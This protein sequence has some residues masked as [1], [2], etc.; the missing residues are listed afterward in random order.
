MVCVLSVF[1]FFYF[2]LPLPRV[3]AFR[4]QMCVKLLIASN[5][6]FFSR[7]SLIP[8]EPGDQPGRLGL[9]VGGRKQSHKDAPRRIVISLIHQEPLCVSGY[10]P[11]C[12]GFQPVISAEDR[13]ASSGN[14]CFK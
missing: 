8:L 5:I 3:L 2:F 6:C 12:C 9:A 7:P 11:L 1:L 10:L 13:S 4:R 14:Q